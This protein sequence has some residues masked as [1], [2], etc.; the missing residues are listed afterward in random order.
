[1]RVSVPSSARPAKPVIRDV[2]PLFRW[3]ERTE[4]DQPFGLRRTR[5]SGLRI[6]LERPWFSSGEGEL[7]GL[8][9]ARGEVDDDTRPWVS[10]WASDPVWRQSGPTSATRLPLVDELDLWATDERDEPGRPVGEPADLPLVDL[11]GD[12]VVRVLGYR[13]EYSEQRGLWFVDVAFDPGTAFWPFVRLAVVRHQPASVP[14]VHLSPVVVCDFAQLAPERIATLTRPDAGHVRVVVTGAVGERDGVIQTDV[15]E[16]AR[17][18]RVLR[19]RVER[20]DPAVGTDLG[21]TTE[22]ETVLSV[23]GRDGDVVSWGDEIALPIEVPPARPGDSTNWRV[24]VEEWEILPADGR[25]LEEMGRESRLIYA[26]HL[27]L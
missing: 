24:T 22:V 7:L 11:P 27:P 12:P 8:L 17:R 18:D 4:P 16:R 15:E 5:R 6:Y 2:L 21:W 23:R 9:L 25:T 20:F 10:Q 14:G 19:A 26:D 1:M 3:G 13:P